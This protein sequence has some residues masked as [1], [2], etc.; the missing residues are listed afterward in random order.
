[1]PVP[2]MSGS[3]V[4]RA[5][6]PGRPVERVC[7]LLGAVLVAAG[8]FHLVVF[9]VDGGPWHGPVSWRKPATFGPSFGLTLITI[10]WVA[11]YLPIGERARGLLL[12]TFAADCLVEVGGI[13]LQTWRGVP[14]HVNR[15]TPFDSAVPTLLAV[16]GGVLVVVLGVPAVAAFRAAPSVPAD[17]RPALR[18]G[19]ATLALGLL[20]GAVMIARGVADVASGDQ[21]Q[22]YH[23]AGFL[24]PVHGVSLHGVLV[25][26]AV[27][28]LMSFTGW[29]EARRTR[30]VAL[31][32]AGYAVAAAVA[33]ARS[34]LR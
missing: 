24:K 9:A 7:R 19:F 16:G 28:R 30:A 27:A 26:P 1:M 23:D 20:S 12:G 17:M 22:A 15:E 8:L 11:S 31:V 6:R 33:L 2:A 4:H 25:L 14:S 21:G 13:T 29:D 3:R 34:P 32:T 18:A 5:G 10:T